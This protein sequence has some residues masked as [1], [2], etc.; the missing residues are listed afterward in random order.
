LDPLITV[1]IYGNQWYWTYEYANFNVVT[2]LFLQLDNV[3]ISNLLD[4]LI[5]DN[6]VI[7][8]DTDLSNSSSIFINVKNCFSSLHRDEI[9][10]YLSQKF[11][12][13]ED[14]KISFDSI[15]LT[16]EQ[17]PKGYPRLLAV[18]QALILPAETSVRLLVT[19]N[20]VIHS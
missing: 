13:V 19:S 3:D 9:I 14:F 10:F 5:S 20:D 4:K 2:D 1:V 6:K 15:I 16:D 7:I 11:K 8:D 17:L 18:D 12:T